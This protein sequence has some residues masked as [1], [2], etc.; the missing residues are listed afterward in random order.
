MLDKIQ[1]MDRPTEEKREM[2]L[3]LEPLVTSGKDVLDIEGLS[4]S[5]DHQKLFSDLNVHITRGEHVA[6]I[7]DNGTGKTTIFKILNGLVPADAGTITL[8][9]NVR[10]L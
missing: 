9:A 10:L 2:T 6:L 8:G 4:K 7:G 5:Y 3:T 1:R